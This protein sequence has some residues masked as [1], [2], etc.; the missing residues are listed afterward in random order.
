MILTTTSV[1]TQPTGD[2][3]CVAYSVAAA[4]ETANCTTNGSAVGVAEMSVDDIFIVG[5]SQPGAV[6]GIMNKAPKGFV[7]ASCRPPG[8]ARCGNP[9]PSANLWKS[10]I[11]A[12]TFQKKDRVDVMKNVLSTVGPIVALIPLLDD[13]IE[14]SGGGIYEPQ[15]GNAFFHAVCILGFENPSGSV[16]GC[17][18]AKNSMGPSW[19]DHGFFRVAW[20]DA[21]VRPEHAVFVVKDVH[22]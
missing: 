16:P 8:H 20:R 4:I 11:E 17:W 21:F 3:R 9:P 14:F 12:V 10:E 6:I 15:N 18:V 1:R 2:Q 19:G 13:F 7:D 22:Q 5:G